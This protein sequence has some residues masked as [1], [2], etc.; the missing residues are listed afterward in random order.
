MYEQDVLTSRGQTHCSR[1]SR[2]LAIECNPRVH[3]SATPPPP[4]SPQ[5]SSNM[6]LG[7]SFS[8]LFDK[9]KHPGVRARRKSERR[10]SNI[11]GEKVDLAS[12]V[13]Q[14]EPHVV[15]EGRHDREGKGAGGQKSQR[16]AAE[17]EAKSTPSREESVVNGKKTDQDHPSTPT[18]SVTHDGRPNGM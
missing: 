18:P 15:A 2:W 13:A 16:K 17:A 14:R 9:L 11:T 10:E 4:P 1:A 6:T 7:G 12:T 8:K 5:P 3:P